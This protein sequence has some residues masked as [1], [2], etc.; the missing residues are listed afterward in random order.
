MNYNPPL[1]NRDKIELEIS[2]RQLASISV[3]SPYWSEASK[4]KQDISAELQRRA[5]ILTDSD[6]DAVLIR[7]ILKK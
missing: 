5:N 1:E 2:L 6:P 3:F 4:M 7:S